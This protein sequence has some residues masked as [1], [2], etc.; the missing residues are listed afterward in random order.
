MIKKYLSM[1]VVLLLLLS[2]TGSNNS[3]NS[4]TLIAHAGGA[5]GGEAMTNSLEALH[6]AHHNGYRYIELDL[7]FTSDSIL[8][9]VHDWAEYNESMGMEERGD[10]APTL[11]FFMSHSLP[12]GHTPLSA[13]EINEFFLTYGNLHFVTDKISDPDVLER[14]FPGLK[15]RMVVE[16]FNYDHYTALIDRGFEYVTY[17][18]MA[19]DIPSATIKHIVFSWLFPGKK[20]DRLSLH[21]SA[22]DYLYMKFLLSIAEFE[23]SLFT[24]NN[25]EEIPEAASH[26]LRFVYTDFMLP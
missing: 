3:G 13:D 5:L 18:C 26:G 1:I 10:S 20:I 23:I 14:F 6:A 24:V 25:L 21:T 8:V 22:F 7:N 4:I 16:A 12:S 2:C 17:S 15:E 9:A 11:A 19:D